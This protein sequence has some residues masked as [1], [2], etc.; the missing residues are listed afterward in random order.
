MKSEGIPD[1]TLE[2]FARSI[3]EEARRYGF[4]QV[5]MVRLINALMD[6]AIADQ[7]SIAPPSRSA[8]T[9]LT[10]LTL[11][12]FHFALRDYEFG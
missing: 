11:R 6:S 5:D 12:V 1:E 9:E 10:I 4:S 3:H 2:V 7:D 8:Q